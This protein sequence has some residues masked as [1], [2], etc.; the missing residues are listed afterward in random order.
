[1]NA[2][3]INAALLCLQTVPDIRKG[4]LLASTKSEIYTASLDIMQGMDCLSK[5]TEVLEQAVLAPD[6]KQLAEKLAARIVEL[7]GQAL[8]VLTAI[9]S[10]N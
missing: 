4:H 9:S 2:E 3:Q 7:N 8:T 6:V 5:L 1:M 10:V